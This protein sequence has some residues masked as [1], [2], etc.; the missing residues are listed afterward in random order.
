M[1]T[2]IILIT[3]APA[4]RKCPPH[5]VHVEQLE[6]LAPAPTPSAR[7]AAVGGARRPALW[8]RHL[9]PAVG[10]CQVRPVTVELFVHARHGVLAV[11]G[12]MLA[13]LVQ[14]RVALL[15]EP[16]KPI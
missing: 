11:V 14:L 10:A 5:P 9:V 13:R 4:L 12:Y 2:L 3:L 7:L 6:H 8:M 1:S 15:A 16:Q